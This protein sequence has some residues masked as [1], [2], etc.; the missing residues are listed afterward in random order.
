MNISNTRPV[1]LSV[2]IALTGQVYTNTV[3]AETYNRFDPAFLNTSVSKISDLSIIEAGGIVPPG[4]YDVDIYINGEYREIK[5]VTF[6]KSD[7]TREVV[8]PYFNLSDLEY[9][10]IKKSF[11]PLREIDSLYDI[12]DIDG[13]VVNFDAG[14]QRLEI[15]IPQTMMET[16]P[17]GYIPES[18]WDDGISAALLDYNMNYNSNRNKQGQTDSYF[19]NL[20]GGLNIGPWRYR[21]YTTGSYDDKSKKFQWSTLSRYVERPLRS[22]HSTFRLGDQN[23]P[24]EIFESVP[25]RAVTL[26]S[27]QSMLPD[28]LLG[29]SPVIR[30]VARTNA[31]VTV[32]QNNY[33]IYEAS[34]SPGAFEFKDVTPV[35]NSG[36]LTVKIKE[37]DGRISQYIVPYSAVPVFVREGT[38]QYDLTAG[39]TQGFDKETPL[40]QGTF[41]YGLLSRA[42]LYG[43]GQ[44][45]RDYHALLA[46]TGL[47]MGSIGALSLDVTQ[48]QS[49]ADKRSHYTGQSWRFLYAKSVQATGTSFQLAG[50]RY[51]TRGFRTLTEHISEKEDRVIT[52][53]SSGI[54]QA[55]SAGNRKESY[56]LTVSQQ[57]NEINT[58]FINASRNTWWNRKGA[59]TLLQLGHSTTFGKVSI[60][61]FASYSMNTPGGKAD[62]NISVSFS[63]PLEIFGGMPASASYTASQSHGRVSHM[64]GLGGTAGE[65]GELQYSMYD[66]WAPDNGDN[67]S[68]LS[69]V[70]Q[71]RRGTFGAG[72]S[73]GKDFH[74]M[75]ASMH[76]GAILHSG[77]LTVGQPLGETNIL[78]E[79]KEAENVMITN[80]TGIRTDSAGYALLPFASNYRENTISV[81]VASL[82]NDVELNEPVRKIVPSKGAVVKASFPV[83]VGHKALVTLLQGGGKLPF[84]TLVQVKGKGETGIVDEHGQV[85]LSGLGN[86]TILM[87]DQ[88]NKQGCT[89]TLQVPE[90]HSETGIHYLKAE[91]R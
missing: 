32:Y 29:F 22:I 53:G 55:S 71:S 91:C 9:Y 24:G 16:K 7:A 50:Y 89:A 48:A 86:T 59:E 60:S 54:G 35:A 20:N 47:D 42:T 41:R 40:I 43:G 25:V 83:S 72:Y 82:G 31:V 44:L 87:A 52:A 8:V 73:T 84:G 10:G 38:M 76:G 65:N 6:R 15:S 17:R 34:V 78:V 62:K 58:V 81:D 88:G 66:N 74:Q 13:V 75:N 39:Q 68:S 37:A 1:A 80:R 67:Q 46:G 23:T 77:G 64:A 51:S 28:S 30:G 63:V 69:G 85:F 49:S 61:T 21:E 45:S 33:P 56:Q 90:E 19:L 57:L 3:R 11:I 70:W 5:R 2:V 27:E 18:R 12:S 79:A 36:E 14:R 4:E 26:A